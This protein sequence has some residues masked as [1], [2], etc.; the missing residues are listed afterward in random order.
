MTIGNL[1]IFDVLL[2]IVSFIIALRAFWLYAQI[3][4]SRVLTLGIAMSM[5]ALGSLALIATDTN[6]L[7]FQFSGSWFTSF[8]QVS[9][10][11]FIWLSSLRGSSDY[12]RSVLRWQLLTSVLVIFLLLLAPILPNTSDPLLSTVLTTFR[13]VAC[14]LAFFRYVSQG[15]L[16]FPQRL[17]QETG[18]Q[19]GKGIQVSHVLFDIGNLTKIEQSQH[20]GVKNCEHMRG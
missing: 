13:G 1:N 3:R 10:F 12:L 6:I 17:K 4:G 5:F 9:G 16:I 7:S 19:K 18:R 20:K 8:A 2:S 14:F 11:V 15:Y